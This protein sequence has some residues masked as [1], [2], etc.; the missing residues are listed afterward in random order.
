MNRATLKCDMVIVK[1]L[2]KRALEQDTKLYLLVEEF[3][4]EGLNK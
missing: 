1:A 3:L 2:K 4:R